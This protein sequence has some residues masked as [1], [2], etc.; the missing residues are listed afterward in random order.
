MKEYQSTLRLTKILSLAVL[1]VPLLISSMAEAAREASGLQVRLSIPWTQIQDSIQSEIRNSNAFVKDLS[2]SVLQV[3][4]FRAIVP[5]G[6]IEFA[7]LQRI[8]SKMSESR[9]EFGATNTRLSIRIPSFKIDQ[10][11][12]RPIEGGVIRVRV[13][14][15]CGPLQLSQVFNT[16]SGRYR[17]N[18]QD[19]RLIGAFE[20]LTIEPDAAQFEMQEMTCQ[21]P[22]GIDT[23]IRQS[24]LDFAK[25]PAFLSAKV[26]EFVEPFLQKELNE[27]IQLLISG[28]QIPGNALGSKAKLVL[29]SAEQTPKGLRATVDWI[30]DARSNTLLPAPELGP[31]DSDFG[32]RMD[33]Q[34]TKSGFELLLRRYLEAQPEW[35]RLLA[36]DFEDFQGLLRSRFKQFFVWPDLFNFSSRDQFPIL[37]QKPDIQTFQL[38]GTSLRLK[39]KTTAWLQAPRDGQLWYY[40]ALMAQLDGDF[41]PTVNNGS[42]KL[43]SQNVQTKSQIGFGQ[44]YVNRYS[45]NMYIA[46][47]VTG[48]LVDTLVKDKAWSFALPQVKLSPSLTV[49]VQSYRLQGGTMHLLLGP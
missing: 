25:S 40:V 17:F 34:M 2:N 14:A 45:P 46:S 38:T 6:S 20:S 3:G 1:C 41:A 5:R 26:R 19:L 29:R 27:N 37:V 30:L 12:E 11:I 49:K 44:D 9:F 42:L 24:L 33:L 23:F 22:Q 13:Q 18:L 35:S 21:G 28:L 43:Q 15:T 39:A 8:S 47:A 36:N 48:P 16:V 32:S 31:D 10:E 7:G 4:E